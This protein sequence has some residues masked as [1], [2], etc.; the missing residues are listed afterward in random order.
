[1]EKHNLNSIKTFSSLLDM[2]D[3]LHTEEDCR[4]YLGNL[5]IVTIREK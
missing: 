2:I 4:E 1:M 3:T 5:F